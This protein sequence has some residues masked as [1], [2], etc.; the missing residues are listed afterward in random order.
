MVELAHLHGSSLKGQA[1][2]SS[3]GEMLASTGKNPCSQA[4]FAQLRNISTPTAI[5][6][7]SSQGGTSALLTF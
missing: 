2:T 6:R 7:Y 1:R 4:A 5:F 3:H